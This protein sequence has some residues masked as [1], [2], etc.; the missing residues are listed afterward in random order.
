MLIKLRSEFPRTTGQ[1]L[2]RNVWLHA[3]IEAFDATQNLKKM[4]L[5]SNSFGIF[6][7]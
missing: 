4:S 6:G 5:K 3:V 2:D 7:T 1:Q